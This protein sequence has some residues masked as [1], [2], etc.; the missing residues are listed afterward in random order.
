M[1]TS[2]SC[3]LLLLG[4][5]VSAAEETFAQRIMAGM[6]DTTTWAAGALFSTQGALVSSLALNIGLATYLCLRKPLKV[7]NIVMSTKQLEQFKAEQVQ[8]LEKLQSE[9][10]KRF[11]ALSR[12]NSLD[13]PLTTTISLLRECTTLLKLN[14]AES[15]AA[16]GYELVPGVL[17]LSFNLLMNAFIDKVC[18][19]NNQ[20]AKTDKETATDATTSIAWNTKTKTITKQTTSDTTKPFYE[21][22]L[23]TFYKQ[24]QNIELSNANRVIYLKLCQLLIGREDLKGES[25]FAKKAKAE[26]SFALFACFKRGAEVSRDPVF[27]VPECI[28]NKFNEINAFIEQH[29]NRKLEQVQSMVP[30]ANSTEVTNQVLNQNK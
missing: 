13:G 14:C 6:W 1:F 26:Q 22:C 3:S 29:E 2:M 23:A 19:E 11:L 20:I 28:E 17:T 27:H 12:S 7:E 5:P 16:T 9:Q 21:S 10:L 15:E 8:Q 25:L 4:S 24:L 30:V 18:T